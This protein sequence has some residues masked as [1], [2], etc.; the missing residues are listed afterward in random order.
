[1]DDSV[2]TKK[3]HPNFEAAVE[4]EPFFLLQRG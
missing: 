2:S 4:A 3:G 1:M